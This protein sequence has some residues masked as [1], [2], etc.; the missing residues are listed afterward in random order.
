MS[1]GRCIRGSVRPNR[2]WPP[3]S[4]PRAAAAGHWGQPVAFRQLS[5]RK[6]LIAIPSS[7]PPVHN[8]EALCVPDLVVRLA[9]RS[10]RDGMRPQ[11]G[12]LRHSNQYT[13]CR[14]GTRRK[15]STGYFLRPL[16]SNLS[17][18]CVSIPNP[19]RF[20]A[21]PTPGTAPSAKRKRKFL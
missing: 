8:S 9:H 16:P 20:Q 15:F 18:S 14:R 1:E 19:N 10:C 21:R 17:L 7:K 11:S 4:H 2:K 12:F 13:G 3:G 5:P 6:G